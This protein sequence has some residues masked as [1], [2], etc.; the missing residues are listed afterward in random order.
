MS[1]RPSRLPSPPRG[2]LELKTRLMIGG[3][4]LALMGAAQATA[5]TGTLRMKFVYEGDAISPDAIDVNKDVEFCGKHGLMNEK[6]LINP[7]NKGIKNVVLYV[8]TGRGGSKLPEIEPRNETLTLANKNCRFDP[9]IV[10]A[11]TGD[12]LKVTNPD[13]VGHNANLNFFRNTAQNFTIPA[14]QEKSVELTEPEP[15][16]IPVDCNIHPWMRAY[17]VVLEH[18][19]AAASDENGMLEIEG[20]PAG[21]ELN[22]RVYHE[23]LA[24]GESFEDV[25]I[26]GEAQG[27]RRNRFDWTVQEG[28]NDVVEVVVPAGTL[29]A[30]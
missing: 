6:V 5:Q 13:P 21:Q 17:V 12:T 3:L 20:L 1:P 7:E 19:F 25:K 10:I 16:P 15:A 11:Q 29:S 22:F 28:E 8:Y 9:H 30:N 14:N 4:A 27:W 18:P 24:Q 2:D 26:D 23:G